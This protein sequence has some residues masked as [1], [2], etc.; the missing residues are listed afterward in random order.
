MERV[1]AGVLITPKNFLISA[2]LVVAAFLT[3]ATS[4]HSLREQTSALTYRHIRS[5]SWI[6]RDG[7]HSQRVRTGH[8][9]LHVLGY[10][11]AYRAFPRHL[12]H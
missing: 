4:A 6:T 3:S 9:G 11:A 8:S 7:N 10:G 1:A 5:P 12:S 2:L